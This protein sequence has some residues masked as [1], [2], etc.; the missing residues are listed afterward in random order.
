MVARQRRAVDLERHPRLATRD[1]GERQV[2]GVARRRVGDHVC[3][4]RQR[5]GDLE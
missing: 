4:A 3:S 5:D 2:R 1:V